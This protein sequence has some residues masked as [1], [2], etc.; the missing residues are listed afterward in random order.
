MEEKTTT[1]APVDTGV[2][3]TQPVETEQATAAEETTETQQQ[4]ESTQTE[5]EPSED[6][7]LA[8][9]AQT[10]GLELDSENAKKAAKMAMEAERNMHKAT[11][12]AGELEKTM[13]T[14]SD[15]SAV[16]TAQATGQDPELIKRLQRMEVKDSI[17]DFW[18]QNP[19]ARKY[20]K[21]MAAI[22]T[23]SGLYGTPDAILK[24]SYAMAV[25]NNQGA[26]K[27]QGKREALESLAHKQQASVPTG[28]ATNPEVTPKEKPFEDLSINEMESRLGFVNR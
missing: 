17:R 20:E 28:S 26:V 14:M 13:S 12:R 11:G 15:E 1:E 7:Q 5:S 24:A 9:F 27:S 6:D 4:T 8:K 23:G 21:E 19:D 22:A 18:D 3:E 25:A 16:Q 2:Q 10:K